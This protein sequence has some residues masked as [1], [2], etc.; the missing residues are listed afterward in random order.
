MPDEAHPAGYAT[1]S[2]LRETESKLLEYLGSSERQTRSHIDKG[3]EKIQEKLDAN[4]RSV[5]QRIDS[6]DKARIDGDAAIREKAEPKWSN[7]LTIG[8]VLLTMSITGL[9]AWVSLSKQV[10]TA[11]SV[12]A[13]Q[14][15]ALV[16]S[17]NAIKQVL[18]DMAELSE[19]AA[20]NAKDLENRSVWMTQTDQRI[21]ENRAIDG[22][23]N[24]DISSLQQSWREAVRRFGDNED[25]IEKL[26]ADAARVAAT[27]YDAD[28]GDRD[29]AVTNANRE[30][31]ARLEAE[32]EMLLEAQP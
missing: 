15:E 12:N 27:R 30:R 5:S 21:E 3:F 32:V 11:E 31:I 23:Q 19:S 14:S 28:D 6:V 13:A 18:T 4:S 22:V 2:D 24:V 10:T 8:A 20:V 26:Q 17:T 16:A 25:D 29:R 7:Y 1:H 9:G